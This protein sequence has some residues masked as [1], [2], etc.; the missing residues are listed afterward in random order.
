MWLENWK[1]RE[2][3]V[4]KES[5]KGRGERGGLHRQVDGVGSDSPN[6]RK[7]E[8]VWPVGVEHTGLREYG[9]KASHERGTGAKKKR[10]IRIRSP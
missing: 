6:E 7:W 3:Q 8:K 5:E 9:E 1:R 2:A 4:V 10:H